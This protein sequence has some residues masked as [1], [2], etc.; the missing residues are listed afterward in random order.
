MWIG[1]GRRRTD[2]VLLRYETEDLYTD[3]NHQEAMSNITFK[4]V[5]TDRGSA[6]GGCW[7]DR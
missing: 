6:A 7:R 5:E 3:H 2:P 1:P 4:T